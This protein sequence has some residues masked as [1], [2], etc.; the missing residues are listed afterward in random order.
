MVMSNAYQAVFTGGYRHGYVKTLAA[1]T[2]EVLKF[3]KE[4]VLHPMRTKQIM[5]LMAKG[6]FDKAIQMAKGML[7]RNLYRYQRITPACT[8]CLM[9]I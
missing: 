4:V 3:G 7:M 6:D 1:T 8:L 5:D 9:K 2:N